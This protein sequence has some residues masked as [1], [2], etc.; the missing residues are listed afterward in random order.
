MRIAQV[1]ELA[2]RD[3]SYH[4]HMTSLWIISTLNLSHVARKKPGQSR[5]LNAASRLVWTDA[6]WCILA[7][8]GYRPVIHD[9]LLPAN[10]YAA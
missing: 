6:A 2:S 9:V 8:P 7:H 10:Q 3:D 5:C 4:N 1:L